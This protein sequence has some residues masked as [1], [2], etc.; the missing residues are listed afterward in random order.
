MEDSSIGGERGSRRSWEDNG[1]QGG[2]PTTLSPKVGSLGLPNPKKGGVGETG[3]PVNRSR[4]SCEDNRD[5][6]GESAKIGAALFI[7]H[8]ST[9]SHSSYVQITPPRRPGDAPRG[10]SKTTRGKITTF[11]QKSRIRLMREMCKMDSRNRAI[12]FV[13]TMPGQL[14]DD[15]MEEFERGCKNLKASWARKFPMI[16]GFWKKEPQKRGAMHLHVIIYPPDD[17]G[18]IDDF[19]QWVMR[20]WHKCVGHGQLQHLR[21]H[22]EGFR[23]GTPNWLEITGQDFALYMAKYLGKDSDMEEFGIT[24][25]WWGMVNKPHL[26]YGEK[27]DERLS[28]AV[29]VRLTR[30][31]RRLRSKRAHAARIKF[32][33]KQFGKQMSVNDVHELREG[34]IKGRRIDFSREMYEGLKSIAKDHSLTL[35]PPT[36]PSGGAVT[37]TFRGSVELVNRWLNYLKGE[38]PSSVH[39]YKPGAR[40]CILGPGEVRLPSSSGP[41]RTGS[42]PVLPGDCNDL[43]VMA[44]S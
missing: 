36:L 42:S 2:S 12:T 35:G 30:W 41:K 32:L 31:A 21:R 28:R 25:R 39:R 43:S 19:R 9:F 26:P 34:R 33:T 15:H 16:G 8:I 1:L 22:L 3:P 5:L 40:K 29:A 6:R 7:G 44:F 24:G 27:M 17:D 23:R 14:V 38:F 13:L 10:E 18:L 11:S 20:Y 4:T 37:L